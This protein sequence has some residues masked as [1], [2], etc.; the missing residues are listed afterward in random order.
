M[1]T[2]IRSLAA[3][4]A[5]CRPHIAASLVSAPAWERLLGLA[6]RLPAAL[7]SCF[8]F[9]CRPGQAIDR[10]DLILG[11]D[12]PGRELLRGENPALALPREIRR[13]PHWRRLAELCRRWR[14]EARLNAQLKRL[15]L[16]FD[17]LERDS[18]EVPAPRIFL[19]VLNPP[20]DRDEARHRRRLLLE[21][22]EQYVGHRAPPALSAGLEA[23]WRIGGRGHLHSVGLVPDS[24]RS[25]YR[26]C[27]RAAEPS[28]MASVL[29]AIGYSPTLDEVGRR[30][31]EAGFSLATAPPSLLDLDLGGDERT[32]FGLEWSLPSL[33][34][35]R[36]AG[37]S[38]GRL[39]LLAERG[40]LSRES[41]AALRLW[42]GWAVARLEHQI[43]PSRLRRNVNHL[44]LAYPAAGKMEAKIYLRCEHTPLIRRRALGSGDPATPAVGR[45]L[46]RAGDGS[47][48][49]P[50][51]PTE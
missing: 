26:L 1:K 3:T 38:L 27:L 13:Q 10:V 22:C 36:P 16:E 24:E 9:E 2:T 42:P 47:R 12:E 19:D 17:L 6:G 43:W 45:A 28:G 14:S 30:L 51:R 33:P 49:E 5:R 15:W 39:E 20:P 31:G 7:S 11:V 32:A 18:F 8:H 4:L 50:W 44:K 35:A 37:T 48:S 23:C 46:E 34:N 40:R 41:L 21:L 25:G 29:S